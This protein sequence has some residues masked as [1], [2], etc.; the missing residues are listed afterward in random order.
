MFFCSVG[1]WWSII[2][3]NNRLCRPTRYRVCNHCQSETL[4]RIRL[5]AQWIE[6][7]LLITD[8]YT[9]D[10]D[11]F[12]SPWNNALTW[13]FNSCVYTCIN[14]QTY[15]WICHQ[16]SSIIIGMLVVF[17]IFPSPA[18]VYMFS[19]HWKKKIL[20]DVTFVPEKLFPYVFEGHRAINDHFPRWPPKKLVGAIS[21]EQLVGSH[22]NASLSYKGL[23]SFFYQ[24]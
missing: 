5:V 17:R 4:P 13:G 12:T 23:I 22:S 14:L 16:A 7:S 18:S 2:G 3:R 21:Y 8:L 1:G 15:K 24:I 19:S 9:V 20:K 6:A 10:N 11:R